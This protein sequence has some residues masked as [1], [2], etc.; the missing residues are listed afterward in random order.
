MDTSTNTND[1][2]ATDA[3]PAESFEAALTTLADAVKIVP[4]PSPRAYPILVWDLETSGLDP[5]ADRI[6]EIG[7]RVL[8]PDGSTKDRSWLINHGLTL[9]ADTV[10][11]TGITEELLDREGTTVQTAI[12]GFRQMLFDFDAEHVT[13]NGV[14]F[15]LPFLVH[16]WQRANGMPDYERANL[17]EWLRFR[18]TDTAALFKGQKL[19]LSRHPGESSADYADRVLEVRV[20]GLRYNIPTCCAELGIDTTGITM[21][22]AL[23]D[24]ALTTEIFRVLVGDGG[25]DAAHA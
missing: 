25:T 24:V 12:E 10:A 2:A 21:H 23:G 11:L 19:G 16:E 13:H 14:R 5:V 7:C 22:R 4:R 8:Y 1:T 3:A 18:V 20:R 6:L 15:D 9:S 17:L